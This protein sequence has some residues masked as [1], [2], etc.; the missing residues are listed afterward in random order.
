MQETRRVA[1]DCPTVGSRGLGGPAPHPP[2]P[3]GPRPP[4]QT[5]EQLAAQRPRPWGTGMRHGGRPQMR[6]G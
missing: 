4:G 6:N 5:L 2:P 3:P 1:L